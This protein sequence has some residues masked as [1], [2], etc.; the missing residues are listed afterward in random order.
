MLQ[1]LAARCRYT[2][3]DA[4]FQHVVFDTAIKWPEADTADWL[5]P[6]QRNQV[7][8]KRQATASPDRE[9]CMRTLC[10]CMPRLDACLICSGF[11]STAVIDQGGEPSQAQAPASPPRMSELVLHGTPQVL[12]YVLLPQRSHP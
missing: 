5:I 4:G 2:N 8:G 10:M 3:F 9:Q 12:K 11:R 7:L 6:R 1:R